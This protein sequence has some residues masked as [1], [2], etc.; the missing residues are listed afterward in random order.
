MPLEERATRFA[1]GGFDEAMLHNLRLV[2]H[3]GNA[4]VRRDLEALP[5]TRFDS[6][7]ILAD[8]QR[9]ASPLDSDA[10]NIATLLLFREV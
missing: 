6:I 1:R 2:H 8:Q 4:A 10:H 9:E 7:L 5:I 3:Q